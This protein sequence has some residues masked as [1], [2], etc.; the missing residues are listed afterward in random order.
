MVQHIAL[1]NDNY[2]KI[3]SEAPNLNVTSGKKKPN[4][5]NSEWREQDLEVSLRVLNI[6]S[7]NQNQGVQ[8]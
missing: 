8:G 2:C 6:Q 7:N 3:V 5:I 4:N 1:L